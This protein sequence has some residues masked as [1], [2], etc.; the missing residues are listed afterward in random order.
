MATTAL[1]LKLYYSGAS[2]VD[3]AISQGYLSLG[4]FKSSIILPSNLEDALFEEVP[5]KDA[6]KG[7]VDIRCIFIKNT[8]AENMTNLSL[9]ISGKKDYEK[10]WF[11]VAL[12]NADGFVQKLSS[13]LEEPYG[14]TFNENYSSGS[15]SVL[16][17]TLAANGMIA[18][19]LK[20]EIIAL[21]SPTLKQTSELALNFSWT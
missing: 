7:R 17:A 11:G 5:V 4:G 19:W 10:I 12:P 14:I 16:Q 15:P 18:L 2:E 13:G 8:S 20:R 21:T 9:Y 1:D 3:E 6:Y